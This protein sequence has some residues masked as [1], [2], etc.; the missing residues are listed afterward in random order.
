MLFAVAPVILFPSC[1]AKS[2]QQWLRL[3]KL[4]SWSKEQGDR[5][6]DCDKSVHRTGSETWDTV[7]SQR[8]HCLDYAG[9]I[10]ASVKTT[11]VVRSIVPVFVTPSA[12]T[13]Y[14]AVVITTQLSLATLGFVSSILWSLM[15]YHDIVHDLLLSI[16][17]SS[18]KAYTW[19]PVDSPAHS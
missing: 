6:I 8:C 14:R 5:Y 19:S 1:L 18:T 2:V 13:T 7:L 11:A 17:R 3:E 9:T 4:L 12:S 16:W 15:C 10:V